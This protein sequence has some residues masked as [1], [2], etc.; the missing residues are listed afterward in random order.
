MV[1]NRSGPGGGGGSERFLVPR[2]A[3]GKK[4]NQLDT[5]RVF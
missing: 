1:S 4:E 2:L 3:S 5:G